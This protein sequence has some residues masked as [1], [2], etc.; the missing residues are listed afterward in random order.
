MNPAP[1]LRR[2]PEPRPEQLRQR[3]LPDAVTHARDLFDARNVRFFG[4]GIPE[5][6]LDGGGS[7]SRDEVERLLNFG[8]TLNGGQ[9]RT[10]G[11][12]RRRCWYSE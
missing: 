10:S 12:Y 8:G 2:H 4:G 6:F 1:E 11:Y 7:V 9:P 3:E 5:V